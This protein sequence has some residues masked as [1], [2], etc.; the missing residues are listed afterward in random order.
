MF[1]NDTRKQMKLLANK[2]MSGNGH[3]NI[4]V[5][6]AI[7]MTTFLIS[8]ILCIGSGYLKSA[9]KQQEMLNGTAADII[10]TNPTQQQIQALQQNGEIVYM[11]VSRQIGFV[12][13]T[14]YPRINSILLRWCDEVEWERHILPAIGNVSGH[15]PASRSEIML[16]VWVLERMGINDP[17]MG[18][19]ITFSF[20]YGYTDIHWQ[21]LSDAEDF[22]FTLCGWYDDYSGNKMYDNA[23][24]YISTDFW[25][26]SVANETNTKSALALTISGDGGNRILSETE[27]F[28]DLQEFTDL[29]KIGNSPN[30][31]SPMIVVLGMIVTIM[32]CGYLLIYPGFS[33]M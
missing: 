31:F 32:V 27:P 2:I 8:T 23:V 30:N 16:P 3:R 28:N 15:Y 9:D 25:N 17:V 1:Y 21:P 24:A 29:T 26:N 4:F 10:L 19:T 12:D 14:A 7:A 13:T 5:I 33:K 20:R 11:G 22:S 6:I 18:Q